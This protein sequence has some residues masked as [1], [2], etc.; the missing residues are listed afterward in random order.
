M[1]SQQHCS[2]AH[3]ASSTIRQSLICGLA[4]GSDAEGF[5]SVCQRTQALPQSERLA[6]VS[7]RAVWM[8][9]TVR[10]PIAATTSQAG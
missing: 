4:N 10:Q 7:S 6:A 5:S 9:H 8:C 3:P 2:E 1:L